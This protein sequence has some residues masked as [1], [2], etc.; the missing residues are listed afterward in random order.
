VV[1]ASFD[2]G[3]A[4]VP[5]DDA[6]AAVPF[7]DAVA[8]VPFDDPAVG[9]PAVVAF[10]GEQACHKQGTSSNMIKRFFIQFLGW[11]RPGLLSPLLCPQPSLGDLVT[12]GQQ[13]I[14]VRTGDVFIIR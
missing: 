13:I 1:V 4:A 5:F 2:R 10:D 7:D 14:L 8:A 12:T 9:E 6:A 3:A 11:D